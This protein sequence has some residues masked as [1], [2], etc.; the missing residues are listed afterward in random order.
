LLRLESDEEPAVGIVEGPSD[1][2]ITTKRIVWRSGQ[3]SREVRLDHTATVNVPDFMDSNKLDLYGLWLIT[4]EGG[5]YS[6]AAASAAPFF[7]TH[8]GP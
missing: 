7:G 8:L 5:E 3:T 4:T 2:L 1:V 6:Q